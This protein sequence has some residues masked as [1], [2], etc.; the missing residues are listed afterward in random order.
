LRDLAACADEV[1]ASMFKSNEIE[2]IIPDRYTDDNSLPQ[3][4]E[5]LSSILKKRVHMT[6]VDACEHGFNQTV[7]C[8]IRFHLD[9]I[10]LMLKRPPERDELLYMVYIEET[11]LPLLSPW[12]DFDLYVTRGGRVIINLRSHYSQ[13]LVE[14]DNEVSSYMPMAQPIRASYENC[15]I[16][17]LERLLEFTRELILT[18]G[19][20]S[21]QDYHYIAPF[22]ESLK[23]GGDPEEMPIV[24]FRQQRELTKLELYKSGRIICKARCTCALHKAVKDMERELEMRMGDTDKAKLERLELARFFDTYSAL[25]SEGGEFAGMPLTQT[26][27]DLF[28]RVR[29]D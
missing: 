11:L 25:R 23:S 4:Q 8:A 13:Q 9:K 29:K 12:F 10:Q 16:S 26:K 15:Q 20:L 27:L 6:L 18:R 3:L 17:G 19:W 14:A 21:L 22:A 2:R 24:A 1:A 5:L 28:N 7:Y